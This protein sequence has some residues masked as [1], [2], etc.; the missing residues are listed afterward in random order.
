MELSGPLRTQ[1]NVRFSRGLTIA[2]EI[3]IAMF[4]V[5]FISSLFRKIEPLGSP[6]ILELI[7]RGSL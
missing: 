3:W 7:K 4:A 6:G 2:K 5:E 1:G